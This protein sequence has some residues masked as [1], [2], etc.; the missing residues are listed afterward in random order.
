MFKSGLSVNS[1]G[2][3]TTESDVYENI[4]FTS[5]DGGSI[6][7]DFS[8]PSKIYHFSRTSA[9]KQAAVAVNIL[10]LS[11]SLTAV[12]FCHVVFR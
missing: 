5:D 3:M 8:N 12:L 9:L 4:F 1:F 2:P 7:Q 10:Q 11:L 6:L